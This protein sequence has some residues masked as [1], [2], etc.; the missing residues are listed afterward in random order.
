MGRNPPSESIMVV[1]STKTQIRYTNISKID[2]STFHLSSKLCLIFPMIW[3]KQDGAGGWTRLET[4]LGL[5]NL[6]FKGSLIPTNPSAVQEAI[7]DLANSCKTE[8][9]EDTV[10]SLKPLSFTNLIRK[11]EQKGLIKPSKAA[12]LPMPKQSS[13]E[14]AL[15]AG[16]KLEVLYL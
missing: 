6:V 2:P 4:K 16:F 14:S 11:L 10:L 9:A 12:K 13:Q 15:S 7:E 3:F 8:G 5:N 1:S